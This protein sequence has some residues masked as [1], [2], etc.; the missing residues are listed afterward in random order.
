MT[1]GKEFTDNSIVMASPAH[2][3]RTTTTDELKNVKIGVEHYL[4]AKDELLK[5]V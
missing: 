4:D 5:D 3:A 2:V 1:Q